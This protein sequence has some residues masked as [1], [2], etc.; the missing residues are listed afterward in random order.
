M[1]QRMV[2]CSG[3]GLR[4]FVEEPSP[5]GVGAITVCV[6]LLLLMCSKTRL[7]ES[8][9]WR[10]DFYFYISWSIASFCWNG[11]SLVVGNEIRS[12]EERGGIIT[13]GCA[14]CDA[15]GRRVK[16]V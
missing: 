14:E 9:R 1:S 11:I 16:S 5:V 8:W 12:E 15:R 7:Q 2:T 13:K 10:C 6:L 3:V 4:R